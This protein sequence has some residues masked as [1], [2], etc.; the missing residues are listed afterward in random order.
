LAGLKNYELFV[1]FTVK[2]N[3]LQKKQVKPQPK[4]WTVSSF[5][6]ALSN[7][8]FSLVFH[9]SFPEVIEHVFCFW[10]CLVM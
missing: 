9:V 8:S 5:L 7:M 4:R 6:P 10:K 3:E 1:F 2:P